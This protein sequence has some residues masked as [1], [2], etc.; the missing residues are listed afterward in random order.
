MIMNQTHHLN[1]PVFLQ[2]NFS[3]KYILSLLETLHC[4]SINMWRECPILY[5]NTAV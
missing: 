5:N 4:D 1:K 3:A 2:E